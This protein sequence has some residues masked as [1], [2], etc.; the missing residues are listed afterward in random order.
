[1]VFILPYFIKYFSLYPF[2]LLTLFA[3]LLYGA[4]GIAGW[5]AL[6]QCQGTGTCI[7]L[8]I[9]FGPRILAIS[10]GEA[11][12]EKCEDYSSL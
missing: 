1:M 8:R 2:L 10:T 9:A 6:L 12:I 5:I 4:C 3:L 11:Y 7:G